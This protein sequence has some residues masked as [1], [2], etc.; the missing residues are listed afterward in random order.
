M[1]TIDFLF[2]VLKILAGIFV[3]GVIVLVHELGHFAAAKLFGVKVNEFAIGMGP[4]I[5]IF[6]KGENRTKYSIRLFPIG[7]FCSMEG[8]DSESSHPQSF[9]SRKL[10]QRFIIII[11]GVAMNLVLCFL[12]LVILFTTCIKPDENGRVA[13]SSTTISYLPETATSYETGLRA[14]DEILS[15]NGK[16]VFTDHDIA[17]LMQSDEDGVMDIV[18]R[19]KADDKLKKVT[20]ND[21]KFKTGID[22]NTGRQYLIYDFAV[23]GIPRTPLSTIV[24]SAKT[25]FSLATMIWRSLGDIIT[26]KY[27]LNQLYGPVGTVD[28]I[29]SVVENA[30]QQ[31]DIRDGLYPLL[32]LVS[33]LTVNIGLLNLLPLP[34]LDGGRLMFLLYEFVFRRPVKPEYEGMVHA[35][36]F[37]LLLILLVIITF[38]DILRLITG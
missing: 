31:E 6:G 13:F 30:A 28:V 33:L 8:E 2:T 29:G 36:G 20:L 24:Q 35:I 26:G 4:K 5:F 12:L 37:V 1:S 27:G 22:E 34:A 19:R 32:L 9:N 11:A 23:K 38:N 3:F 18:V 21:V 15:I 7:G 17:M 14:G 10:W 16:R 25:E